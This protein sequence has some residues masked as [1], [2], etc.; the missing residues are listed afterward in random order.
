MMR[1]A[2]DQAVDGDRR[3]IHARCR[4]MDKTMLKAMKRGELEETRLLVR[5][6][7]LP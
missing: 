2:K 7:L 6:A 3:T 1:R 5:F 4:L